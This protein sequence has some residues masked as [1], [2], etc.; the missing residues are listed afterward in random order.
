[1]ARGPRARPRTRTYEDLTE[2]QQRLY[3]A[4]PEEM[5]EEFLALLPAIQPV[6][7]DARKRAESLQRRVAVVDQVME[8]LQAY[9]REL[10]E[11]MKQIEQGDGREVDLRRLLSPPSIGGV[12]IR[13]TRK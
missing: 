4:L 13:F 2:K 5:R 1:M 11:T 9:R 3:N 8:G 7:P 10:T 12:A 6:S